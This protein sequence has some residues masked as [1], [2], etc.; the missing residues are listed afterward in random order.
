MAEASRAPRHVATV[1]DDGKRYGHRF[2]AYAWL[3]LS[4]KYAE[5]VPWTSGNRPRSTWRTDEWVAHAIG[6]RPK[7]VRQARTDAERLAAFLVNVWDPAERKW[8][9]IR[10]GNPYG[11]TLSPDERT[12]LDTQRR[13]D[14]RGPKVGRKLPSYTGKDPST[15]SGLKGD[16]LPLST[17]S[18]RERRASGSAESGYDDADA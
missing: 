8:H 14:R 4:L 6:D 7:N 15:R 2:T 18:G 16:E 12:I 3:V 1:L 17:L 10:A 5:A 13:R 9:R 11:E